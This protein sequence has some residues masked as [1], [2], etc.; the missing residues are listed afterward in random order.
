MKTKQFTVLTVFLLIIVLLAALTNPADDDEADTFN[1]LVD[2]WYPVEDWE[3]E[4]C[5]KWGGVATINNAQEGEEDYISMLTITLQGEKTVYESELTNE[6][7]YEVAYYIM[8]FTADA[9]YAVRLR[10]TDDG[11]VYSIQGKTTASVNSGA[12]GYKAVYLDK[13]YDV[14]ELK[15]EGAD[16][17][18]VLTVPIVDQDGAYSQDA[19]DESGSSSGT[20]EWTDW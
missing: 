8:P 15:Y 1:P 3:L 6:T 9:D 19:A 4:V 10:N 17:S 13:V 18:G 20:G 7:L 16:G 14:A 2:A 12:A 5:Q 11:E